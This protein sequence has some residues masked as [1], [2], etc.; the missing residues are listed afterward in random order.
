MGD[1]TRDNNRQPGRWDYALVVALIVLAVV[2]PT[3]SP[4]AWVCLLLSPLALLP[5]L[6]RRRR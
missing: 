6:L 1:E 2:V 3:P 4:V 5:M